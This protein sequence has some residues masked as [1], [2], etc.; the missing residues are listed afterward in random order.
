[1]DAATNRSVRNED[2]TTSAAPTLDAL[3]KNMTEATLGQ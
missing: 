3:A 2:F 1:M